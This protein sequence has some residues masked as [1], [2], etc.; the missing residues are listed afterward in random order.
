MI[1]HGNKKD[2][3]M[4]EFIFVVVLSVIIFIVLV[5]ID[6]NEQ[7]EKESARIEEI[8]RLLKSGVPENGLEFEKW[9]AVQ[10]MSL[11]W[12]SSATRGSGDQGI[13]VIAERDGIVIGFQ[14]KRVAKPASNKA[15]QEMIAG[16]KFHNIDNL[17]VVSTAGFT[18]SAKQLAEAANVTLMHP[19][20]LKK[21]NEALFPENVSTNQ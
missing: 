1:F 9:V 6:E 18:K 11:G 17:V 14:C 20:E 21:I 12:H 4:G 3:R 16:G 2:I 15:V 19:L 8:E 7:E 5:K 13:D 10:M